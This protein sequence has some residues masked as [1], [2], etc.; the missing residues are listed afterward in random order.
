MPLDF[1]TP[2]ERDNTAIGS[3]MRLTQNTTLEDRKHIASGYSYSLRENTTGDDNH[4]YRD[5]ML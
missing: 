2:R 5:T 1:M 3:M 4:C